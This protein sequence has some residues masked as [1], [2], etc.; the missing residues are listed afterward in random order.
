M[1]N[2]LKVDHTNI[3]NILNSY[4]IEKQTIRKCS[5][6]CN[7][8]NGDDIIIDDD[9]DIC[10]CCGSMDISYNSLLSNEFTDEHSYRINCCNAEINNSSIL[11]PRSATNIHTQFS[12]VGYNSKYGNG[13]LLRNKQIGYIDTLRK[14]L[15]TN[16]EKELIK[17]E[18]RKNIIKLFEKLPKYKKEIENKII[19]ENENMDP[20]EYLIKYDTVEYIKPDNT[21]LYETIQLFMKIR[22]IKTARS[23]NKLGVIAGCLKVVAKRYGKL[24]RSDDLLYI[25]DIERE[26]LNKGNSF[27]SKICRKSQELTNIFKNKNK[28]FLKDYIENIHIIFPTLNRKCINVIILFINRISGTKFNSGPTASSLMAWILKC[29]QIKFKFNLT[30]ENIRKGLCVSLTIIQRYKYILSYIYL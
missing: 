8:C 17:F 23:D 5:N 15:I 14:S 20:I 2:K 29:C 27:I 6:I 30:D 11:V 25:F 28:L 13:F 22:A 19:K 9:Q 10:K 12:F 3:N 16:L 26:Y 7:V 4:D 24:Y 21:I 18:K 1:N